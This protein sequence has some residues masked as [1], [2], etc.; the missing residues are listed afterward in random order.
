MKKSS[1][2]ALAVALGVGAVLI[3]A[4]AAS[5][6]P[7]K[8]DRSSSSSSSASS[9]SSSASSRTASSA[10]RATTTKRPS[11]QTSAA[12]AA[13]KRAETRKLIVNK[14]GS[15]VNTDADNE[16]SRKR[17]SFYDDS[18]FW[19]NAANSE[20]VIKNKKGR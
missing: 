13:R 19:D 16:F 11:S 9:S 6:D 12:E 5:A 17:E 14:P 20:I 18:P 3:G 8:P 4:P 7:A 1:L 15:W 2:G 10:P